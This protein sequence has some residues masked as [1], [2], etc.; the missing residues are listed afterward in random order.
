MNIFIGNFVFHSLI[1]FKNKLCVSGNLNYQNMQNWLSSVVT[2]NSPRAVLITGD[3]ILM[4]NSVLDKT[5]Y[6]SGLINGIHITKLGEDMENQM[7]EMQ[8]SVL[9]QM[10]YLIA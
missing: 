8:F 4:Q 3:W 6:G 7:S 2:I 5:L 10:V 9:K 1:V